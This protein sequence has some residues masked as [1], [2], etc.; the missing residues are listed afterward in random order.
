M[1]GHVYFLWE[2]RG[3]EDTLESEMSSDVHSWNVDVAREKWW[4]I[5]LWQCVRLIIGDTDLH[6]KINFIIGK[7]WIYR[8]ITEAVQSSYML[9]TQFLLVTSY[10]N[11]CLSPPWG[12]TIYTNY[13]EFWTTDVFLPLYLSNQLFVSMWT[14]DIHFVLCHLV[15]F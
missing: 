10:I 14:V 6:F 3:A 8:T 7:L 2:V 13:L 11:V 4:H 1:L 15:L 9:D 12:G 5:H